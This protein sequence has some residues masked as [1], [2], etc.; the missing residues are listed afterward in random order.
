MA[1]NVGI[2]PGRKN[3]NVTQRL[4]MLSLNT[5]Q[6]GGGGDGPFFFCQR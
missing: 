2:G 6:G 3:I 1:R 4:A 5:I